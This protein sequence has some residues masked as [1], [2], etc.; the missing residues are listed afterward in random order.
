[1]ALFLD[2]LTLFDRINLA[3]CAQRRAEMNVINDDR[4]TSEFKTAKMW[5]K[6]KCYI[7]KTVSFV[8]SD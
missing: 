8:E 2:E 4:F 6:Y 1:M 3:S 7:T 5:T